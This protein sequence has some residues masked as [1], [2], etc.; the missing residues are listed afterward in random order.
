[1]LRAF[2]K[3]QQFACIL[4]IERG[5]SFSQHPAVISI[6]LYFVLHHA[7]CYLLTIEN[8]GPF[9]RRILCRLIW[10]QS[11]PRFPP[12]MLP[13]SLCLS[14][15]HLS[16]L[17]SINTPLKNLI[18]IDLVTYIRITTIPSLPPTLPSID[19]PLLCSP[20]DFPSL[21]PFI[22]WSFTQ[23]SPQHPSP[24]AWTCNRLII[25]HTVVEA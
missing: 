8:L 14:L 3:P 10:P 9:V 23:S 11:F 17:V 2:A 12:P 20:F 13:A 5:R 25:V 18:P 6:W 4:S 22:P 19:G 24:L 16:P 21:P 15:M 1:M 7:P